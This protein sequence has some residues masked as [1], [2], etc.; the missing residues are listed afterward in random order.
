M[1]PRPTV[2]NSISKASKPKC[3]GVRWS[4]GLI[5]D[6][7]ASSSGLGFRYGFSAATIG[8][9]PAGCNS[10]ITPVSV[11]WCGFPTRTTVLHK[12]HCAAPPT[13]DSGPDNSRLHVGQGN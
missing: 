12:G 9:G 4:D 10:A 13:I 5:V 1:R 3:E 6:E 2:Q 11:D 8:G 7:E